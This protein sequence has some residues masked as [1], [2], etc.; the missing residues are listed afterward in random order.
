MQ[1]TPCVDF[2]FCYSPCSQG[3]AVPEPQT[4]TKADVVPTIT[5]LENDGVKADLAGD[6][7]FTRKLWLRIGPGR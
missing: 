6:P 7:A 4:G 3:W 1:R 2:T 5:N